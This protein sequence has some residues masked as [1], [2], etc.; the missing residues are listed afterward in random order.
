MVNLFDCTV[1]I[2]GYRLFHN[3]NDLAVRFKPNF[4]VARQLQRHQRLYMDI[5]LFIFTVDFLSLLLLLSLSL[6]QVFSFFLPF[7]LNLSLTC[8]STSVTRIPSGC[9]SFL[10][11]L[12][13]KDTGLLTEVQLKAKKRK[14]EV[15]KSG[16]RYRWSYRK[17][18][19]GLW[20][21]MLGK[22]KGE[23]TL[24]CAVYILH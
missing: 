10:Q 1:V 8:I 21:R 5:S 14:R 11:F 23:N 9:L 19:V 20:R 24:Y 16:L 22:R 18:R 7:V 17:R 12:F 2:K 6:H 15:M 13:V 3:N 4:S